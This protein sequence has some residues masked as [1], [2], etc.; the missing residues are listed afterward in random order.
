M[1]SSC[2]D[3]GL[4][5]Q[6]GA[7]GKPELEMLDVGDRL[8]EQVRDVVV[9]EVVDDVAALA[10]S[11]DEAEVA[12]QTQLVGDS[13]GLHADSLGERVDTRGARTQAAEYADA[14]RRRERLHGVGDHAGEVG[15]ELVWAA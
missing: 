4:V 2:G 14:A 5:A 11:D 6:G 10:V 1:R 12:Q 7:P 13:G 15:V 8:V 9:V 3:L